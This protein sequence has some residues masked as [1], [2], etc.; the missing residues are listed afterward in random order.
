MF[1]ISNN[2]LVPD[3]DGRECATRIEFLY[4]LKDGIPLIFREQVNVSEFILYTTGIEEFFGSLAM[5]AGA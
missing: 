5:Y 3:N 2:D 4:I 1:L